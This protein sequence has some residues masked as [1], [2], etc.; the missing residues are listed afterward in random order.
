MSSDKVSTVPSATLAALFSVTDRRIRQLADDGV[1]PRAAR[2]R[3]PLAAS[4][5]GY[6]KFLGRSGGDGSPAPATSFSA[7]RT[8][9]TIARAELVEMERAEKAATLIPSDQVEA[10]WIKITSI[11]RTRLLAI[12]TKVALRLASKGAAEIEREL[13]REIREALIDVAETEVEVTPHGWAT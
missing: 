9:L 10:A 1:I 11:I 4:I 5:R 6:V 3:Y 7:A 12:P 2:G 8:R 13:E